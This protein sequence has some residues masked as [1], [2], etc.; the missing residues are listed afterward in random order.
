MGDKKQP[1]SEADARAIFQQ[2][3]STLRYR[4][5]TA[6][7]LL[8]QDVE[9]T[10]ELLEKD[11]GQTLCISRNLATAIGA[12]RSAAVPSSQ[13]P[14]AKVRGRRCRHRRPKAPD[15]ERVPRLV[16]INSGNKVRKTYSEK[17]IIAMN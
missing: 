7:E 16:Q 9:A 2:V 10:G 12:D 6:A 4:A 17:V 13:K 3:A 15:Q 11:L 14:F 1:L 8:E 5:E